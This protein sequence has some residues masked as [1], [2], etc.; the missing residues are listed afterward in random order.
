MT[1]S[2][3][4][5]TLRRRSQQWRDQLLSVEFLLKGTLIERRLPCGSKGCRC[6]TDPAARHGPYYQ[7]TRKIGEKTVTAWLPTET[8]KT[9]HAWIQNGRKVDEITQKMEEVSREALMG[10]RQRE[11]KSKKK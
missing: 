10:L 9:C 5:S 1:S 7:W 11:R 3:I 4:P 2:P 8:A 6:H